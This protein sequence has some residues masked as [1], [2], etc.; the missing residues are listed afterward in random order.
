MKTLP[1]KADRGGPSMHVDAIVLLAVVVVVVG[2][3][4][5]RGGGGG[6]GGGGAAQ[7]C[8]YC[9]YRYSDCHCYP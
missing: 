9:G 6:G 1:A 3:V 8:P 7:E 5:G 4:G 2:C